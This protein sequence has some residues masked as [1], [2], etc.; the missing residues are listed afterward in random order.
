[1]DSDDEIPQLSAGALNALKEFYGDRDTK[2]K[3]FED[4]KAQAESDFDGEKKLSMDAFTEDWNA[5][6]F[7]YNDETATL[8]AEQL[9]DGATDD[10]SIV[11]V[12]AP[13]VFIQL[14]NLLAS[15]KYKC[16]PQMTL[17]EFDERFAVFKEFAM[18]DFEHPMRLPP[19]LKGKFDRIICDPP[20]LSEDCQTKAALTVRWLAK[21]WTTASAGSNPFRLI[22]CTGERMENLIGKLYSKTGIQTTSFEVKHAKGL[23]NEF[24]CYSNF[25]CSAWEWATKP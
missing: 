25:E 9:L 24:R 19:E 21:S 13:S 22:V 5:S 6:Q 8:L 1:M 3:E 16:R 17:L 14:K 12:S 15:R 20:F 10:S 18:Y 11:V 7:W 2:Q 23:S 4:L